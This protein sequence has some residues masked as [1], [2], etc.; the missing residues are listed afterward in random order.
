M[1]I[2]EGHSLP[3]EDVHE[4]IRDGSLFERLRDAIV[5]L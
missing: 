5:G 2:D 1:T 3:V 4:A